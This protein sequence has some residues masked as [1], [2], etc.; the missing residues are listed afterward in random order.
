MVG[1]LELRHRRSTR[2]E[3][4]TRLSRELRA[5]AVPDEGE[6]RPAPDPRAAPPAGLQVH[7]GLE[8]LALQKRTRAQHRLPAE[9]SAGFGGQSLARGRFPTQVSGAPEPGLRGLL[10][11]PLRGTESRLQAA[12]HLAQGPGSRQQTPL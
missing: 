5:P 4:G 6:G 11:M 12:R 9:A 10:S 2:E 7:P 1:A 3:S 8:S